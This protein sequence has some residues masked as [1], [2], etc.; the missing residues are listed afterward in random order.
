[1]GYTFVFPQTRTGTSDLTIATSA[2]GGTI[3]FYGADSAG[4]SQGTLLATAAAG[5][6]SE[7]APGL[8]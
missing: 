4:T 2:S 6:P 8:A 1:M 3:T 7:C 5:D